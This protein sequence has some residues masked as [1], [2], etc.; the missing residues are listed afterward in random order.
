MFTKISSKIY[1]LIFWQSFL[2]EIVN[3][4]YD[5]RVFHKFYFT[6]KRI[7]S[8]HNLEAFLTKQYHIIEK[9]LSL[10]DPRLGFGEAKIKVLIYHLRKYIDQFG[11]STLTDNIKSC[12]TE[13]VN[14]NK[15]GNYKINPLLN[16]EIIEVLRYNR[17]SKSG[18]T[19]I[20]QKTDI[21]NSFHQGFANFV[22][23]RYSIRNFS[24][25]ELDPELIKNAIE[26]AKNTPSVCNRQSWHVHLF[27]D[28]ETITELLKLQGGNNGFGDTINK[29]LIVTTN[30]EDFT[31]LES[32][33]VYVDGG[34]F[35]MNLILSLHSLSLGACCLN[36]C[37]P[38]V[39]EKKVKEIG[40][41]KTQE[42]L[43]MMIATGHLKPEIKVAISEKKSVNQLITIH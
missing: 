12:L 20:I 27:K 22:K 11:E 29:L 36:T 1:A 19:K 7:K 37:F 38:Y 5:L 8:K 21:S 31:R 41:I 16:K 3:K 14:F 17:Q 10:P 18:G 9:G 6:S 32:N 35:S 13:Y 33:Q 25:E 28:K 34:L 4:F 2:G 40:N 24:Q 26:I 42:K 15:I 30:T 39:L 23:T 43:I